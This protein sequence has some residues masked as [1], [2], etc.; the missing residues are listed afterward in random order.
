MR[1][2]PWIASRCGRGRGR[3]HHGRGA[4]SRSR[5]RRSTTASTRNTFRQTAGVCRSR[6]V[7]L[8]AGRHSWWP[9]FQPST[10]PNQAQHHGCRGGHERATTARSH[11]VFIH[12][13]TATYMY[14][15]TGVWSRWSQLS[16][17]KASSSAAAAAM[18]LGGNVQWGAEAG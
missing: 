1:Y 13:R 6:R 17:G 15:H 14:T 2:C 3:G 7:L 9:V 18:G 11:H 10:C 8:F 16:E 12:L 5:A 4:A